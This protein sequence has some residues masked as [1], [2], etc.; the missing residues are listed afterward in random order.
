MGETEELVG[1]RPDRTRGEWQDEAQS[2]KAS[3][4]YEALSWYWAGK[5]SKGKVGG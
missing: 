5:T 4:R 2:E 3:R 1:G